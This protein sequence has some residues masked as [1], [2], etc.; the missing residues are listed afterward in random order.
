MNAH[1]KRILDLRREKYVPRGVLLCLGTTGELALDMGVKAGRAQR[2]VQLRPA[3]WE[4]ARQ[5]QAPALF[6]TCLMPASGA[7]S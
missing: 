2:D 3:Q 1:F 6:E 4:P 7:S 5:E